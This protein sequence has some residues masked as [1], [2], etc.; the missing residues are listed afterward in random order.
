MLQPLITLL[1]LGGPPSSEP[2]A[3]QLRSYFR[4]PP[5]EYRT[6]PLWVWNDQLTPDDIRRTLRS[7][8]DQHVY[9]AF[10]HPR[11]GLVTPY[12]SDEW[13][14]LWRVALREAEQLG[15]KLW[16]YDENSYPS[17]FAGGWVPH[18]MPESRGHGLYWQ[19]LNR[20]PQ[21][22]PD[23]VATLPRS[24][25]WLVARLRPAPA[26]G[27]FGGYWYVDLLKPGV[28]QKFL[29]IT[30]D[31]YAQHLGQALGK[32]VPGVFTDEPHINP[33]GGLPWTE[34]LVDAFERRFGYDLKRELP[35]LREHVG[36]WKRVRHDYY[37]LLL[38]LFL[39][40]WCKP[41][42]E[43]CDRYGLEWTGH[44][45]EHEW[46]RARRVPDNM[47]VYA[48]HHRP[49][50][51]ILMNRY[52]ESVH[53]QFGNVRS[54]LE[55]AS[56]ARQLG[57]RRTLCEI[58]GAAGWDLRFVDMKRIADWNL[59]LGINTLCEHLSFIS[60]RGSR[61]RDH[62]QSFSSHEPWWPAYHVLADY[63]TRL[64]YV[65][66][67]GHSP[68]RILVLEPTT[69][70]WMYQGEPDLD[71]RGEQFQRFVTELAQSQV[72]FDL[73]SERVLEEHGR[74][75]GT[76]FVVGH[77]RYSSIVIPPGME[78]L[79]ETT[80]RLLVRFAANR[81]AIF[82]CR[83]VSLER[84]GGRQSDR[85]AKLTTSKGFEIVDP[86][87]LPH[88]LNR[89]HEPTVRIDKHNGGI[90]YH[91]RRAV[92]DGQ[93]LFLVNTSLSEEANV[94]VVGR[95]AGIERWDPFTGN[96]EPVQYNR[97]GKHVRATLTVPP[98]GSILL[99]FG[100]REAPAPAGPRAA[101]KVRQRLEPEQVQPL[102]P[103]V[104]PLDY[105]DLQLSD[106]EYRGLHFHQAARRVFQAVGLPGNPWEMAVQ[107][108]DDLL[109]LRLPADSG[110]RAT[111]RFTVSGP[112]PEDLHVVV[113]RPDLYAR[114]LVN[115][116]AVQPTDRWWLDR[117][118]KQIPIA[119]FVREG[120][121]ELTLIATATTVFHELEPVYV[122]GSFGLEATDSGFVLEPLE[123]L[124]FGPWREQGFPFYGE[125]V[126][127]RFRVHLPRVDR[128]YAVRLLQWD[129]AV[130]EVHVNGQHAGYLVS[131]PWVC[132]VTGWLKPGRNTIDVL[133]TGTL[134]NTLGPHHAGPVR[135]SA[136][137]VMFHRAPPQ[138]PPPGTAYD[139]LDYGLL[140]PPELLERAW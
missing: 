29:D 139:T 34:D 55:V 36:D 110:F 72:E 140:E 28:T 33:A 48:W 25:R 49:A 95:A 120:E 40:R 79:E 43:R 126:R 38:D 127:Y 53:G 98:A 138:G 74:V 93:F 99:F 134:R 109:N 118:F 9:Q 42:A 61:K 106:G 100:L 70:L 135:G 68:R 86:Q 21:P 26:R 121:N 23:I 59:V 16:I 119:R 37:R 20:P 136:W 131:P 62:P 132:P 15:M 60:I 111:Y 113:E 18:T 41:Y 4:Q 7:L 94:S 130:A 8:A 64:C 57:R 77:A 35:A 123:A 63:F 97:T 73:G 116:S 39:E 47:A 89:F 46:P 129:G 6:A 69:S 30:L 112:V 115:G 133:V 56:V 52:D 31:A 82:A 108:R 5:V 117:S 103:N 58:F 75:E 22:G 27:W 102:A 19:E 122:R 76:Q 51:D 84:I 11:P 3:E 90:L 50:I 71:K 65:L 14:E 66:S 24:G 96:V 83:P 44:Y 101:W 80:F 87:D 105:V 81:G 67:Q 78:N 10:V 114:I 32:Q 137:P 12:L 85:I 91:E 2:D 104:L 107:F 13:F 1:L 125:T 124:R 88:R 92:A 54:V 45:W 17:G 128:E